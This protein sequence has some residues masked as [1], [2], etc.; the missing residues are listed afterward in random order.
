[1]GVVEEG[2]DKY[3]ELYDRVKQDRLIDNGLFSKEST[4]RTGLRRKDERK[5]RRNDTVPNG[6]QGK[7]V[8]MSVLTALMHDN[9]QSVT[10]ADAPKLL[11]GRLLYESAGK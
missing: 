1:M 6:I 11:M 7:I 10:M 9:E 5:R 4:W 3:V 8:M 2:N